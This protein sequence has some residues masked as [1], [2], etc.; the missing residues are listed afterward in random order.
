VRV[1]D[2]RRLR[3]LGVALRSGWGGDF[4]RGVALAVLILGVVFAFSLATGSIRVEGFTRPAPEGANV[5][6]YLIG[7]L[8]AFLVVG[9]YEELMFRGYVLQRLNDRAGKVASVVV[10]SLIF[11]VFHGANPQADVFGILNTAMIGA[12]LCALYFRT[13]SLWMSIGFHA[14]WNFSL[15][16]VYSLPVSGVPLYGILKVVEVEPGSR[17][18]GGS[19]GPEAG[20]LSTI[21]IALLGVWLIWRRTGRRRSAGEDVR[22]GE[23]S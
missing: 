2:R 1:F 13:G 6:T 21:V 14:A 10:S 19:Y 3:D 11:A 17:L 7:A 5:A 22:P 9:F 23:P 4:A 16:Y 15:G 12:V 8:L 18:T 20:L